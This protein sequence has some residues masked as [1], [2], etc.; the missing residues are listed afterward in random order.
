MVDKKFKDWTFKRNHAEKTKKLTDEQLEW[1]RLIKDH[2]ASSL[3]IQP[4]DL[5]LS[6]FDSM[7]GLGKYYQVFGDEYE[8]ILKDLN[9]VLVA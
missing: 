8:E 1:L 4:E 7:G 2:I 3:S 9:K 5:E 6:P